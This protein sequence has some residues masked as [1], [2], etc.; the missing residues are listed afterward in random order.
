MQVA[1]G[2]GHS[3]VLTPDGALYAC[4]F[5]GQA[6]LGCAAEGEEVVRAMTRVPTL[7]PAECWTKVASGVAHM[8]AVDETG[9]LCAWGSNNN[10]QCGLGRASESP[11][12]PTHVAAIPSTVCAIAAGASHCAA[13]TEDGT[14]YTWGEG[15][16]SRLG[17]GSWDDLSTPRAI[18]TPPWAG[19]KPC[20]VACG[21]AHTAVLTDDGRLFTCG[22]GKFGQLGTGDFGNRETFVEVKVGHPPDGLE[23]SSGGVVGSDA[24]IGTP[25]A[26]VSANGHHMA[27]L[28]EDG[29]LF[30]CGENQSGHLGIVYSTD[31]ANESER[32]NRAWLT[33]VRLPPVK[34]VACGIEHTVA[35]DSSGNMY[36]WGLGDRGQLGAGKVGIEKPVTTPTAAALKGATA[37]I[38]AGGRHTL[39]VTDD[40]SI[41]GCGASGVGQLG[42]E[43]QD[44]QTLPTRV[45]LPVAAH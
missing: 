27:V 31:T 30:M 14:V 16:Y 25:V 28:L 1:C 37:A 15:K 40:G 17:H 33:Q 21:F 41:F 10:G 7:E 13:I 34:A 6:Q 22:E 35:T 23:R 3:A 45:P 39:A 5:N 2:A 42:L 18:A 19:A 43:V 29:Q 11:V 12:R 8:L 20:A 44:N 36:A 32:P 38:A 9:R 26:S 24:R 4:G